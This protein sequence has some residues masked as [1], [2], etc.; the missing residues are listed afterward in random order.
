[1]IDHGEHDHEHEETTIP[2]TSVQELLAKRGFKVV[3]FKADRRGTNKFLGSEN[4][5]SRIN[6][7]EHE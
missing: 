1:M 3:P 2:E 4:P 5:K 7:N 6:P